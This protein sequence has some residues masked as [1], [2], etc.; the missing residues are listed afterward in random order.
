LKDQRAAN[1]QHCTQHRNIKVDPLPLHTLTVVSLTFDLQNLIRSSVGS[2]E[3]S[4]SVQSRLF[5]QLL[6][7]HEISW[8][9]CLTRQTNKQTFQQDSNKT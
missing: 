7:V 2:S 1:P 8:W 9:Q 3:Y 6:V 4:L 5:E